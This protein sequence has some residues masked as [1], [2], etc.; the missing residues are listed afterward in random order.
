MTPVVNSGADLMPFGVPEAAIHQDRLSAFPC[1]AP[2]ALA[3]WLESY[4]VWNAYRSLLFSKDG[5][6]RFHDLPIEEIIRAGPC[7]DLATANLTVETARM[8]VWMLL[9]CRSVFHP[10]IGTVEKFGGP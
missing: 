6:V 3:S 4:S 10:A 2:T 1:Y 9:L 5:R 8:L 7:M